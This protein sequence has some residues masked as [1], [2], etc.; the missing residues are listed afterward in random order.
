MQ[1]SNTLLFLHPELGEVAAEPTVS[2]WR[3]SLR[4]GQNADPAPRIH[5]KQVAG[6]AAHD[7]I[8]PAGGCQGQVLVVLWIVALPYSFSRLDPLWATT[9]MSRIRLRRSTETKRSNLGRKMT[10]RY[11]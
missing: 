11:S 8:R 7:H 4:G 9:T 5:R 2:R 3:D 1:F 10:S 6:I